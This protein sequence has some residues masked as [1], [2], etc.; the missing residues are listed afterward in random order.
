[1]NKNKFEVGDIFTFKT[2]NIVG[3]V[4]SIDHESFAKKGMI[5]G[6]E[7]K[8]L[9]NKENYYVFEKDIEKV[10]NIKNKKNIGGLLTKNEKDI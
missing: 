5:P 9:N 3:K 4:V 2:D 10:K 1:M 6:Y 8:S 7:A